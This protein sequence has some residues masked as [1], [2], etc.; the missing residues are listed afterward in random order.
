M[1]GICGLVDLESAGDTDLVA[2]MADALSHRGPDDRGA[3][4]DGHAA[5]AHTRLSI[6]DLSRLGRQ[7]MA[8]LDGRVQMIFNGEIYNYRELR[9]EL[10]G[11][12]HAFRS[13]SDSEV[14]LA[15]YLEWGLDCVEHLRGMW[16]FA[17]WDRRER[18]LF[19]AVDRFGIKP[20]YYRHAGQRLTFASEPKAFHAAGLPLAPNPSVVRDYIAFGILDQTDR[21]FFADVHRLPAAHSLVFDGGGLSV[22]R[23]WDLPRAGERPSDP[24]RAV[25]EELFES[26]RLHLRSDVAV[27]T[28][29]S[30][31]VDSSAVAC[32]VSHLLRTSKDAQ[33]VG[34]R[35]RTFTAYFEQ[36]G[37]DE[38]PFAQAVVAST[39]SEPHWVTFDERS[40]ID[41]LP[42][43]VHAQDEP[44][45][46]TSIVAQWY[47]MKA[48]SEAGLKV[49]LDGQGGDEIFAG[50]LTSYGPYLV[51]LLRGGHFRR[52]A[53]E[54]GAF[55]RLQGVGAGAVLRAMTRSVA[56]E[57]L[58]R[59]L[60][61]RDSG[62]RALVGER[63]RALPQPTAG[64]TARD[65]SVLRRQ[66]RGLVARVQLPE[67]LRYEDRNSM[68]HSIEARV[69]LL[70]HRLVEL[71]F[72]LD[73]RDLID[74]GVTKAVLRRALGD[75]LPPTVAARTDKLGF[76][77]PL[78]RWWSGR[79]GRFAHEIFG[80]SGCRNRG[81]VDVDECLRRLDG[82]S[83][84]Q[85]GGF[86]LWR[87][88]NVELWAETFST[89]AQPARTHAAGLAR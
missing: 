62:A 31:G 8:A 50:Y 82:L 80:S 21:T 64:G 10:K 20:L 55:R 57:P 26:I 17:I 87:A 4:A 56:P 58:V 2:R 39:G 45:G 81:F 61:A 23:Y 85:A 89:P 11:R 29:L 34:P 78:E 72:S 18:R 65:R 60:R 40:L 66:L 32:G 25:R 83:H 15:A 43:I 24:V 14:L 75:L 5:L 30:G 49:M 12:G 74:G 3:Y 48:A 1:C 27:G 16:A 36:A 54:A 88:L 73:G 86:E 76:V 42:A 47:V 52:F 44:F 7:P 84:G 37:F 77:T 38:R 22:T 41:D 51:D 6:I 70:D 33:A 9:Q 13:E 69:P 35:Q 79:F 19:C 28:C 68:A 63:L 71:A 59:R 67:L 46:S 53:A